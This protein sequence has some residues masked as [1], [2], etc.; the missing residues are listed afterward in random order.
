MSDSL[1]MDT[2]APGV[3]LLTLN[4]PSVM[5]AID[6][7]LAAR[8]SDA[9]LD[10]ARDDALRCIVITG[11]GDR[12]FCSGNDIREMGAF[13][14]DAMMSAFLIRDPINWQVANHP[15]PIIAA[16]NGITYGAGALMA[17]AADI[18]IGSAA[19]R[20]KVTATAYSGANATWT[21]PRLVGMA[22]AKE[23]LMMG[24]VV[25]GEEALEIG[26]LNRLVGDGEVVAAAV[27]MAAAIAA[28]PP[29]GV[30][31]VKQ[32]VNDNFGR[33]YEDAFRAEFS[34]MIEATAKAGRGGAEVF[35]GFLKKDGRAE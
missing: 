17:A 30:Q 24:R 6:M 4:R 18:R 26:L 7:E 13:D 23:I 5:N 9:L 20:F 16:L 33:S 27:E 35:S 12:A 1:I 11:A 15:K 8:L 32:L 34:W 28:N 22:K 2:P 25:G 19:T 14:A 10:A 29:E 31:G 21:L 3:L